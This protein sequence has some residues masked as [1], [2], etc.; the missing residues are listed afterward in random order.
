MLLVTG[1][2]AIAHRFAW[3]PLVRDALIVAVGAAV[4]AAPFVLQFTAPVGVAN[5][6]VPDWLSDLPL[7]GRVFN[8]FAF[9]SWRPSS[10][11]ELVIVH[12]AWVAAFAALAAIELVRDRT[13]FEI[14]RER[15][16]IWLA[17]GILAFGVA[18]AWAPAVLLLGVPLG[19]ACWFSVRS[20]RQP[21]RVLAG[22][23][24]AGF[25]LALIPEFFYIQDVFADRMNTVFKLFF[26]AWLMLSLASAAS[27]VYIVGQVPRPYRLPSTAAAALLVLATLPYTPL[28]AQ[29]WS[30]HFSER[31]GL[32]G[33]A[34]LAR[35]APGDLAAI[36]W[37]ME[38][39]EPGDSIVEAPG[40]AYINVAG[41][42]MSRIS[43]FTGIP[44]VVGWL[45]HEG[46]WRRG[47][48]PRIGEVLD[49]RAERANAILSGS[50]SASDSDVRFVILGR[51][52]T[53]EF[54]ACGFTVQRGEEAS[55]TLRSAGWEIAF[56]HADMRIFARPDDPVV[57]Q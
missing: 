23:F 27:L 20:D 1:A 57:A 25:F 32:D 41:A 3:R 48:D 43:A 38:H 33:R 36:D 45:N 55:A 42:P 2:L 34:Y 6:S 12:G 15:P 39:A 37:I 51:Q 17:G 4:M 56:E 10:V 24:A 35:S 11:R 13:F 31:H 49:Q 29:D 9:V 52:E 5:A 22:L 26:Q 8:T 47:E 44:T 53:T 21:V 14:V 40:C 30:N 28:S 19:L 18:M 54:P 46:Q 50:V 7:I 16:Q